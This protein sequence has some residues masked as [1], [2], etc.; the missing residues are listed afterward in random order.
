M[1]LTDRGRWVLATFVTIILMAIL[2]LAGRV[3]ADD[4]CATFQA[5]NDWQRALAAN[6][7]FDQLPNGEYPYTW[8][9]Q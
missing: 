1:R 4:Q 8:E 5:N 3:A 6:C 9:V 7:S 2:T